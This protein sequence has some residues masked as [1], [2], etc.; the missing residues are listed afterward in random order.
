MLLVFLLGAAV[1]AATASPAHGYEENGGPI[2]TIY[3]GSEGGGDYEEWEG[4]WEEE[5]EEDPCEAFADPDG[6][7]VASC[8]GC[9]DGTEI[10]IFNP[11]NDVAFIEVTDDND[12]RIVL[13]TTRKGPPPGRA[14]VEVD[15]EID[16]E[17]AITLSKCGKKGRNGT[18][19]VHINRVRGARTQ[20]TVF[21]FDDPFIR[22]G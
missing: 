22:F 18:N 19:C 11:G 5:W 14:F 9:D 2:A 3:C 10:N 8:V 7:W 13:T 16:L 21:Y 6:N 1:A 4:E 20:Y 12:F 17:D 15:E